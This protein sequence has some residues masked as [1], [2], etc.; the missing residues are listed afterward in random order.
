MKAPKILIYRL[1]QLENMGVVA[2]LIGLV[3]GIRS[4]IPNAEI[5]VTSYLPIK[6]KHL[7]NLGVKLVHDPW[8]RLWGKLWPLSIVIFVIYDLLRC[9]LLRILKKIVKNMKIP[10]SEYDMVIDNNTEHLKEMLYGTRAVTI[11]MVQTYLAKLIFNRPFA[12]TP[13]SVGPFKTKFNKWLA[14]F[15]FKNI[16]LLALREENNLEYCFQL[17][18]NKK[19]IH[20]V[21]DP[22]FLME[23]ASPERIE[24]LLKQ[25]NIQINKNPLIGFSPNWLEMTKFSFGKS[26][27]IDDRTNNY[28]KLMAEFIDYVVDK[29]NSNVCLI[30]HV[31]GG[32]LSKEQNNDREVCIKI[33]N[34]VKNKNAVTMIS[35]EY[36]PDELKGIIG[37][38]DMFIGGRMHATIA[39]T[40]LGIPTLTMA[41]GDKFYS[42]IGQTMGQQE[43]IID[44]KQTNYADI[45]S[46]FKSKINSLWIKRVKVRNL[47][48]ERSNLVKQIALSYPSLMKV[49]IE[50]SISN[51]F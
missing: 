49:V 14:K 24:L 50:N 23:P 16:D 22:G 29:F 4:C 46:E 47:L 51:N 39:S 31:F 48:V 36:M 38:C 20:F 35:K 44:L 18:L 37:C 17:G 11:S 28:I 13:T 19:I 1:A 2:T 9:F 26:I 40:S 6:Y 27:S 34:T 30:P 32:L 25:E 21:S 5:T 33:L 15:V 45:Q 12:T 8:W 41:Y 10:Y 42:I 43:Y 3:T 7:E